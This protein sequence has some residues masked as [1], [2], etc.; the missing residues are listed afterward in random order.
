MKAI[1][2]FLIY[3]FFQNKVMC[4]LVVNC[5]PLLC[6][7]MLYYPKR[8]VFIYSQSHVPK[9]LAK[10]AHSLHHVAYKPSIA[11]LHILHAKHHLKISLNV[12]KFNIFSKNYENIKNTSEN[13][14]R[15][16]YRSLARPSYP[17]DEVCTAYYIV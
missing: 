16:I 17:D 10:G 11:P 8:V 5:F 3:M 15:S 13:C 1:Q 2:Y 4:Y 12:I 6:N 7:T 9:R 14:F